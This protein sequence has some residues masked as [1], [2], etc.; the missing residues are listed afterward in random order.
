MKKEE[1]Q[2]MTNAELALK[3]YLYVY[4]E[5]TVI[6][7]EDDIDMFHEIYERLLSF[8]KYVKH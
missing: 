7:N 4:N 2:K 1:I 5:D 3:L 6:I 8:W